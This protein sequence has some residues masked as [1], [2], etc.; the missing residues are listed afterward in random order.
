MGTAAW[1]WLQANSVVTNESA[2]WV[3]PIAGSDA[4]SLTG[5]MSAS[6]RSI[7]SAPHAHASTPTTAIFVLYIVSLLPTRLRAMSVPMQNGLCAT[8]PASAPR[9]FQSSI[10]AL[11]SKRARKC[12]QPVNR[13]ELDMHSSYSCSELMAEAVLPLPPRPDVRR[14]DLAVPDAPA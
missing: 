1:P 9:P 5:G 8:A 7:P 6:E 11:P 12:A 4:S 14:F 10:G 3:W 2:C 13:S